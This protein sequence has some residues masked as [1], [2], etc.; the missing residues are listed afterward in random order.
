MAVLQEA[1]GRDDAGDMRAKLDALNR[2]AMKLGQAM[3]AEQTG[4]PDGPQGPSGD[5]PGDEG[6]VDAEFEEVDEEERRRRTG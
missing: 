3:Y 1:M 2:A 4:G 5:A 6:V